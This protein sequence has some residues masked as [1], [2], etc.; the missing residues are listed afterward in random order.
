MWRESKELIIKAHQRIKPYIHQT[1]I[2]TCQ[3]IIQRTGCSQLFFKC[4]NFQKIGAFKPRG[5]FNKIL[6]LKNATSVCTHSSGNHAQGLAYAA[7]MLNIPAYIVM[8]ENSSPIKKQAVEGY[9]ATVITSGNTE[10]E[11][12]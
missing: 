12:R 6:Q 10:K 3:T 7:K 1:P 9:G 2:M 11:R 5:A 8:P 4:E